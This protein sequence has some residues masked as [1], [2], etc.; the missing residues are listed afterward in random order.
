M[1]K[2]YYADCLPGYGKTH[3]AVKCMK[4]NYK[5]KKL[6]TVYA[7]PTHKL[8]SEVYD[9]LIASGIKASSIHYKKEFLH[10]YEPMVFLKER[11]SMR[12]L[13]D[14]ILHYGD[15]ILITHTSL[16]SSG[17]LFRKAFMPRRNIFLI[18]D[19]CRT[20]PMHNLNVTISEQ[21]ITKFFDILPDMKDYKNDTYYPVKFTAKEAS[22]LKKL[23]KDKSTPLY[24]KN[25]LFTVKKD[26]HIYLLLRKVNSGYRLSIQSVFIPFNFLSGWNKVVILSAMFK[27][28]QFYNIL[29]QFNTNNDLKSF[30]TLHDITDKVVSDYRKNIVTKRF[31]NLYFTYLLDN[32]IS[33]V[34]IRG[35]VTKTE[36]LSLVYKE[37]R[38]AYNDVI[39][40]ANSDKKFD[41]NDIDGLSEYDYIPSVSHYVEK[42]E[43]ML[44]TKGGT[45][46]HTLDWL[47]QKALL[48]GNKWIKNPKTFCTKTDSKFILLSVNKKTF[49]VED[50]YEALS[51]KIKKFSENIS[52]DV[53]GL[54]VYREF[55]VVAFFASLRLPSEVRKW[56]SQ[57]CPKYDA[58]LDT[59]IGGAI[60]T[61]LRCSVRSSE[62]KSKPLAIFTCRDTAMRTIQLL[63]SYFGK[64]FLEKKRLIPPSFFNIGSY[65]CVGNIVTYSNIENHR[66]RMREYARQDFVKQ[67]TKEYK[68]SEKTKA[69]NLF[70]KESMKDLY[71]SRTR[72]YFKCHYYKNTA[73][74][75]E[76]KLA[77]ED[78]TKT[79]KEKRK[80]FALEFRQR[81]GVDEEFT[82]RLLTSVNK[83]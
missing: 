48:V 55:D 70:Y 37:M 29:S 19:E 58:D 33:K 57:F 73:G 66:N 21:D 83:V 79:I 24:G 72:I 64:D 50:C 41:A 10:P 38:K 78:I 63:G 5:E 39:S 25:S 1:G 59:M 52:G 13:Q 6:I 54:N 36:N 23:F 75:L 34:K 43:S 42:I 16:W 17:S 18:I 65:S 3:W 56:F 51:D 47:C 77:L 69:R 35:Y 27:V 28:S 7:A 61:I 2:I 4:K 76:Y 12:S 9:D 46:I 62:K 67:R 49:N 45:P 15:I 11:F 60:Q 40:Y 53:R 82:H 8:L 74:Y 30:I 22:A 14:D 26:Q 20:L 31:N 44:V 81:W 80:A 68:N 71:E 32:N